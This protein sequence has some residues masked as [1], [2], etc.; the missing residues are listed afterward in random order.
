MERARQRYDKYGRPLPRLHVAGE[1]TCQAPQNQAMR[2]ELEAVVADRVSWALGHAPPTTLTLRFE[3]KDGL[4]Q[5]DID[6]QEH[7]YHD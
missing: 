7:R 2:R 4:L 3:M 1:E 5:P 6:V